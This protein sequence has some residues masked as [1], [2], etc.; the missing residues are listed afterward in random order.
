[1]RRLAQAIRASLD[2]WGSAGLDALINNAATVPFWQT[3]TP[4]GV[5]CSGP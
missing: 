5:E 3:L 1:V 2:A 4:E